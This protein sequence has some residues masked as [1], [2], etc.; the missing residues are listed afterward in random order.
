[1]SRSR[2]PPAAGHDL[3]VQADEIP[4]FARNDKT[5]RE[6]TDNDQTDNDQNDNDQNH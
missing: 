3:P 5:T 6:V 2:M 1:M 4:R